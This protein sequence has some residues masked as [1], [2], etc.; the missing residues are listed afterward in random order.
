M[1]NADLWS[2]FR[3][4]QLSKSELSVGGFAMPNTTDSAPTPRALELVPSQYFDR[5]IARMNRSGYKLFSRVAVDTNDCAYHV[6]VTVKYARHTSL[7]FH[8]INRKL[9]IHFEFIEHDNPGWY[10][11]TQYW[12]VRFYPIFKS[13][14]RLVEM[15]YVP[16][17]KRD[18]DSSNP[19]LDT[20]PLYAEHLK[21]PGF[22]PLG[23]HKYEQ[24]STHV[25]PLDSRA[26]GTSIVQQL[27]PIL[28][29]LG[30]GQFQRLQVTDFWPHYTFHRSHT[31]FWSRFNNEALKE[32]V[33]RPWGGE[34]IR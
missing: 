3:T 22:R 28:K 33:E 2:L 29:Y 25:K 19:L 23:G 32:I 6:D 16:Y 21:I 31:I 24:E 15:T 5:L 17:N 26:L 20:M 27:Y 11:P 10:E 12:T 13:V 7:F 34:D 9:I 4:N 1:L 18:S 8:L 14:K 30:Y